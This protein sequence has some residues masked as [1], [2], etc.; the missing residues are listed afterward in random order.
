MVPGLKP[1]RSRPVDK[2]PGGVVQL[3]GVRAGHG[4]KEPPDA[5]GILGA[6]P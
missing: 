4:P 2:P 6:M 3:R 1:R 5:S